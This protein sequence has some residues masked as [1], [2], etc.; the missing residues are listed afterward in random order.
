[1]RSSH[2]LRRWLAVFSATCALAFATPAH[3]RDVEILSSRFDANN[4]LVIEATDLTSSCSKATTKVFLGGVPLAVSSVQ[5]PTRA[6]GQIATVIAKLPSGIADGSYVLALNNGKDS[7]SS[8]FNVTLGVGG[9]QGPAG[10]QGPKGDTG[11]TGAAGAVGEQGDKGLTGPPGSSGAT[12]ATGA[13]GATGPAGER[14]AMGAVG[15]T[16]A[17]GE[18]GDRGTQGAAGAAGA[19][20]DAGPAGIAGATGAKGATGAIGPRGPQGA[21]GPTGVV[22][23]EG[24]SGDTGERGATGASGAVGATGATGLQGDVG[25]QGPVGERGPTGAPGAIGA[26][27]ATGGAGAAGTIGASGAMGPQGTIGDKGP[28]GPQ[29]AA[30]PQGRQGDI[31]S[32]GVDGAAGLHGAVGVA[33]PTEDLS[34]LQQIVTLLADELVALKATI[35]PGVPTIVNITIGS[36]QATIAFTPPAANGGSA[37]TS[38]TVTSSPGGFT[39]TG[40]TSPLTVT[41][42]TNGV[43]YTFSITATNAA[44]AGTPSSPSVAVTPLSVPSAPTA[45][46]ATPS[47]ATGAQVSFTGSTSNGGSAISSYRVTSSPGG[48]T[49]TGATSPMTVTG[50]TVGT[51]YTFTVVAINAL[52]TSAASAPSAPMIMAGAPG[53]PTITSVAA[54][55]KLITV[56]FSAPANTGGLPITLYTATATAG[57]ANVSATSSTSPL[58]ITGLT[59]GTSYTVKMTATTAFGTSPASA[60]SAAVIPRGAPGSPTNVVVS[61]TAVATRASVAFTAPANNGAPITSYVVTATWAQGSFATASAASPILVNNLTLGTSYRFTVTA[62]NAVGTSVASSPSAPFVPLSVPGA[63]ANVVATPSSSTSASVSFTPPVVTG[64]TPITSYRV[65]AVPGGQTAMGASSPVMVSGLTAGATYTFSI[66][67]INSRGTGPASGASAAITMPGGAVAAILLVYNPSLALYINARSGYIFNQSD[68]SETDPMN[69]SVKVP[70]YPA[71][72]VPATIVTAQDRLFVSFDRDS[73]GRFYTYRY[74][75][76]DPL[77]QLEYDRNGEPFASVYGPLYLITD[78]LKVVDLLDGMSTASEGVLRDPVTCEPITGMVE[79]YNALQTPV[80]WWL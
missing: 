18:R 34:D 56:S 55:D 47:G 15:A 76:V 31:G 37:P 40:A 70:P 25:P 4:N 54:G 17:Q 24:Q 5:L 3:A 63:P 75:Y 46:A 45:V 30:G 35:V 6:N 65:T 74:S 49:A 2:L 20:G 29:G 72:I 43:A 14:G 59:N 21:Q 11:A 13:I 9:E 22:G 1:L 23:I 44:G 66:V 78:T 52:G 68:G 33:G 36:S 8:T 64:G 58:V 67:A 16:G 48:I 69:G 61:A 62:V 12:G 53:A 80:P 32:I 27:G 77:Q 73:S 26:K 41:G 7:D 51:T 28:R 57:A 79:P 10:P 60:A 19:L 39:A 71:G 50:L 38:Y 42:L